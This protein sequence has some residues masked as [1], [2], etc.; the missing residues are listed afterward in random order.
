MWGRVGRGDVLADN[1][2]LLRKY[3]RDV[4]WLLLY[5]LFLF[6]IYGASCTVVRIPVVAIPDQ[7]SQADLPP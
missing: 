6:V 4:S 5:S 7:R 3:F 2:W 1:W